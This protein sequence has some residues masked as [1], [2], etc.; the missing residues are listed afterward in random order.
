MTIS[1]HTQMVNVIR[2]MQTVNGEYLKFRVITVCRA[3]F[4]V[5]TDVTNSLGIDR[6]N[7]DP[8]LIVQMFRP[9]A[10]QSIEANID[11]T[12]VPVWAR[13]GSKLYL[14]DYAFVD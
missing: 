3:G 9:G 8:K 1:A 14:C 4:M 7:D 10:L 12:W 11:D 6:V 2:K 5:C 13:K